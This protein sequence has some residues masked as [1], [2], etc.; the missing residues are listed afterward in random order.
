M[1][2]LRRVDSMKGCALVLWVCLVAG[3]VTK[4]E[5]LPYQKSVRNLEVE[6][7]QLEKQMP[8]VQGSL[9]AVRG[10]QADIKADMIDIRT[11]IQQLRGELSSGLHD[12]DVEGQERESVGESVALQLSYLQQ[13][14]QATEAR[15]ARIEDYF[16]LKPPEDA[17]TGKKPS[18]QGAA[19]ASK[20]EST[21]SATAGGGEETSLLVAP[22]VAPKK[23]L[24]A[25][26]A[27]DMAY[28]LFQSN[29]NEAARKALDQFMLRYP[30][31]SL[32][33]NALFWI[34]ETY[35]RTEDYENAVL[36]YQQV[37]KKYPKGSKGPDA[38]LKMG[39][40]LEKMNEPTAAVA[41]M[42]KLLK[43]Y[44][45]APQA[46]LATLKIKQLKSNE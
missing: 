26:E 27:Y 3:C 25:E 9:E 22:V 44:P 45:K 30:E 37:V 18:A 46:K 14:M 33:D 38:L 34:G 35:Y 13:Q 31:S 36:N 24:S 17:R 43:M 10:D 4:T 28:H 40:A 39:Y 6:T 11:E 5:F 15:L 7:E 1:L 20:Q 16:G 2:G 23:E 12:K 8:E 19:R 29:E 41:A 21:P 42:E 32:V